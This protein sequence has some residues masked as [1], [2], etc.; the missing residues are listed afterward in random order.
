MAKGVLPAFGLVILM[1]SSAGCD[2]LKLPP[3]PDSVPSSAE[4]DRKRG[5]WNVSEGAEFKQYY[6]SGHLSTEGRIKDGQRVGRWNWYAPD[7]KTLTTTGE[8]RNG[9]RD[10]LWRHFDD[11]G[12]LYLTI[13]YAP[14]PIDPVIGSLSIDYGNENG[15][16]RRFYP[17]GT[18]EEEGAHR[19]GKKDGPMKRY[20][21]SGKI[22]VNG[23]YSEGE[24]KG[25]WSYYR[26]SGDLL[27]IETYKDGKL[28]GTVLTYHAN[29]LPHSKTL[30]RQGE[31]V[32][33]PEIQNSLEEAYAKEP[34]IL[35]PSEDSPSLHRHRL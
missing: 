1:F 28:E 32:G 4:F 26:F 29:G 5:V 3:R 6:R 14:E 16:Y 10:G 27:R 12:R 24:K 9:R 17:D 18:L 33:A 11:S 31:P 8:Y 34:Y 22:M 30:Y 19:A 25:K 35:S 2:R 7:G 21:P 15:P 20:H 23:Q 13:E